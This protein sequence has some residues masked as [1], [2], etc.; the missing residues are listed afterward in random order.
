MIDKISIEAPLG[1]SDHSIIKFNFIAE[2]IS[3]APKIQTLYHKG[4]YKA[5]SD[6]LN[7]DWESEMEAFSDDVDKQ[8]LFFKQKYEEAVG[9]YVPKK[10]C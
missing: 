6:E 3:D 2:Q 1:K 7:L 5:I 9:K 10:L 8:W 4:N